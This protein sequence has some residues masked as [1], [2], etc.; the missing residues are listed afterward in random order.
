MTPAPSRTP[1]GRTYSAEG[2][3]SS[4]RSDASPASASAKKTG[5]GE[6]PRNASWRTI[7]S[8]IFLSATGRGPETSS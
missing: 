3:G 7:L 6:L 1:S 4:S 5:Y 8:G 2:S